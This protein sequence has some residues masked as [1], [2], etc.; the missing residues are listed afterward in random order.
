M[1]T[2]SPEACPAC[3]EIDEIRESQNFVSALPAVKPTVLVEY[4][5][6]YPLRTTANGGRDRRRVG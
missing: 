3:L 2:V 5:T 1:T 4:S 6:A